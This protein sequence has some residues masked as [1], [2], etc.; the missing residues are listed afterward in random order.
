MATG[1]GIYSERHKNPD[2]VY[3]KSEMSK[4]GADSAMQRID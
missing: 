3:E 4:L 2:V 1:H